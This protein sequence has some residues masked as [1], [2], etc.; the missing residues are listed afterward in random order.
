MNIQHSRIELAE[1]SF[2]RQALIAHKEQ[3][4]TE[5]GKDELDVKIMALLQEVQDAKSLQLTE[6]MLTMV[7]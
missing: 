1:A 2:Y 4:I 7:C 6:E 5:E 3:D